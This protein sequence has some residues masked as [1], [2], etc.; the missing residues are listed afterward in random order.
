MILTIE[1]ITKKVAPIAK[2]YNLKEVY[3]FG[4]Y[5]RGEAR[6]DSDIDLLY[7]KFDNS[8]SLTT[9]YMLLDELEDSLGKKVDLVSLQA[10]VMNKKVPGTDEILENIEQEREEIYAA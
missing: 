4:S 9:K 6:E 5:A 1:E 8:M 3:L 7:V 2:K 10:F